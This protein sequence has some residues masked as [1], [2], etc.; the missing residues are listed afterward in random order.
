MQQR[1][2]AVH[3]VLRDA[4]AR[5]GEVNRSQLLTSPVLMLLRHAARGR[6]DGHDES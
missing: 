3:I 2:R 6:Q 4:I 1:Y 5:C